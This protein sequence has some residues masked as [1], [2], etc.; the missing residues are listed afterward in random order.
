M[1][2]IAYKIQETTMSNRILNK[3]LIKSMNMIFRIL[4]LFKKIFSPM[5]QLINQ[6]NLKV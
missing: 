6:N 1:I 5:F 4:P 3:T 2:K